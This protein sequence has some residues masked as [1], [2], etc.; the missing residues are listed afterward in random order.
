M[1]LIFPELSNLSGVENQNGYLHKDVFFH[2]LKVVDN[3]AEKSDNLNLRFTSLLHDIAKPATKKFYPETGWTFYGHDELGSKIVKEIVKRMRL[4][5]SLGEYAQKLIRMHLRP[6]SLSEKQVT[7]SAI[8][9][10]IV[11]A[12]DYLDDLMILCKA[13]ITSG[14]PQRVVTHLENFN[15]VIR[16]IEEVTKHDKLKEFQSPVNGHEIM[17]VCN[18][19]PCRK[20]GILKKMLEDAILEGIIPNDH[21]AAFQYLLKIKDM[22]MKKTE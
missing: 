10:F 2:T 12:G 15:R 6:I 8:R 20:V 5:S 14:N 1:K 7:D 11:E 3:V 13:D 4:P 17:Q 18:L 21:E 22:N 16:R 19:K 9:R